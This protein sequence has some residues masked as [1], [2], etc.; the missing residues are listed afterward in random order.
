VSNA[1]DGGVV[2]Y[3]AR[4]YVRRLIQSFIKHVN[5]PYE[6]SQPEELKNYLLSMNPD[7]QTDVEF[8][9]NVNEFSNY[10]M[11]YSSAICSVKNYSYS[12]DELICQ[13]KRFI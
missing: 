6:F 12:S 5:F 4:S 7:K 9:N 3:N 2:P 10:V 13:L 1:C 11:P 8:V